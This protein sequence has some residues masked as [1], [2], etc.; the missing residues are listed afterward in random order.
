M[1]KRI[2][3][4]DVEP[5]RLI[6]ETET[7]HYLG[8]SIYEFSRRSEELETKLGLPKA[9][10]VLGRRDRFAIDQWL[11]KLFGAAGKPTNLSDLIVSRMGSLRD[12][13]RAN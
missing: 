13:E 8:M 11:D 7:A 1:A 10:P 6:N 2:R 9:H 4:T 5:P 12:G 3:L